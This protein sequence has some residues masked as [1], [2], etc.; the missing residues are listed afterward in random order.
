MKD[1]DVIGAL[2]YALV[3]FWVG[4]LAALALSGCTSPI[5]Q[6]NLERRV[7]EAAEYGW[8][9]TD[10]PHGDCWAEDFQVAFP[11]TEAEYLRS[12]PADS[13]ACL[14]WRLRDKG[15]MS[16]P[17]ATIHPAARG[18]VV[19]RLAVHELMHAMRLCA[20]GDEDEKHTDGRIWYI[21]PSDA[22]TAEG[23][24]RSELD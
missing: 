15:R 6:A 8:A 2:S 19:D 4:I 7:V 5:G 20:L 11:R 1:T 22:E 3:A 18:P 9:R 12:C 16:F 13:W 10:L 21:D 17:V 14:S 24:A 23:W